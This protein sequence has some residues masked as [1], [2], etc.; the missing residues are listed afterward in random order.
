[1]DDRLRLGFDVCLEHRE[2]P[3]STGSVTNNQEGL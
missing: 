1:M 3:I 2:D